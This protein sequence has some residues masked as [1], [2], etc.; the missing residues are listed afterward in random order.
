MVVVA[1]IV[2][3]FVLPPG[4][5]ILGLLL[6][7]MF[8]PLRHKWG[9]LLLTALLYFLSIEPGANLLLRPLEDAYPPLSLNTEN[10]ES[11]KA[12][13]AIVVLGGGSVQNSPEAGG[14]S[15][16]ADA[17]KR[18]VY[19]FSL[20]NSFKVPYIFSGGIVLDYGQET[21]AAAA[22]RVFSSL[23]LPSSRLILETESRNTWENAKEMTKRGYK[24]VMLVTSAY[25]MRRSVFCFERN[26]ITVI[27]APADYKCNRGRD[28]D[29]FSYIPAM[30][31]FQKSYIALHEYVGL[32]S[33]QVLYRLRFLKTVCEEKEK[34]KIKN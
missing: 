30:G 5:I 10:N 27:P 28:Y 15:L 19:A 12:I 32:F 25:H 21:E 26:G 31:S 14:D 7:T 34:L 8:V 11:N 9:L 18:A 22:E 33:Y 20:R 17:I 29:F 23:G 6:I 1:Q 13:E 3:A 2:T 16:S 24:K 4:C